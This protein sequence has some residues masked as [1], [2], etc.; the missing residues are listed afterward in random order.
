[1]AAAAAEAIGTS[2]EALFRPSTRFRDSRL[3]GRLPEHLTEVELLPGRTLE[4]VLARGISYAWY[5]Y[6]HRFLQSRV[7]WM[8]PDVYVSC[9]HMYT[10]LDSVVLALRIDQASSMFIGVTPDTAA[11]AATATGDFLLRLM[12][13]CELQI[14]DI[15][16]HIDHSPPISGEGL[17]LFFRE[18][19]DNLRQVSFGH[20]ILNEELIRALVTMSRLDVE[21]KISLCN[22]SNGASGSFI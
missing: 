17:S 6:F 13:T 19:R 12:A 5:E 20:T 4:N 2:I 3:R 14:A 9:W 1:M 11:A 15:R 16:G 22:L 18:S 8:T 21:V 10:I 7:V